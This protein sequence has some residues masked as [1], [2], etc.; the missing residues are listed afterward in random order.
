MKTQV[1]TA[2][3]LFV[4]VCSVAAAQAPGT[5]VLSLEEYEALRKAGQLELPAYV[6]SMAEFR[7]EVQEEAVAVRGSVRAVLFTDQPTVIPLFEKGIT[8]S[9]ASVEGKPAMLSSDQQGRIA[10]A[11]LGRPGQEVTIELEFP[12]PV[13]QKEGFFE[14]SFS[15]PPAGLGK[16]VVDFPYAEVQAHL[17]EEYQETRP[18]PQGRSI[19]EA[20]VLGRDTVTLKWLPLSKE[21]QPV[22]RVR[23]T[24]LVQHH[25]VRSIQYQVAMQ[26][27]VARRPVTE[28]SIPLERGIEVV[29]VGGVKV[30]SHQSKDDRLTI[31][32]REPVIGST[33]LDIDLH[34]WLRVE[35]EE[36]FQV[37][38]IVPEGSS[39]TT[40]FI[41]FAASER[42]KY[43]VTG[44]KNIQPVPVEHIPES[45]LK[46]RA[47]QAFS[48][49]NAEYE[50]TYHVE[51]IEPEFIAALYHGVSFGETTC[52]LSTRCEC[53]VQQGVL[54]AFQFSMPP[55]FQ[56]EAVAGATVRDWIV[57]PEGDRL[58]VV[59][60]SAER[61][62]A[63]FTL[64]YRRN[65]E[66]RELIPI[67]LPEISGPKR[68]RGFVSVTPQTSVRVKV[69]GLEGLEALDPAEVPLAMKTELDLAPLFAYRYLEQPGA[70]HLLVER[71]EKARVETTRIDKMLVALRFSPQG[72]IET[73]LVLE[74]R[75]TDLDMLPVEVFPEA[76]LR[77]SELDGLPR[78]PALGEGANTL[79]YSVPK[80]RTKQ[81]TIHLAYLLP[82][83]P[84]GRGR[85]LELPIPKVALPIDEFG[86]LVSLPE[87]YEAHLA[88]RALLERSPQLPVARLPKSM[89]ELAWVEGPGG[90]PKAAPPP[91][92]VRQIAQA[93]ETYYIDN[94]AYPP[95]LRLLTTPVAHISPGYPF[96][97][98]YKYEV[99]YLESWRLGYEKR[100]VSDEEGKISLGEGAYYT[101]SYLRGDEARLRELLTVRAKIQKRQAGFNY[102]G[103]LIGLV[104]LLVAWGL[105]RR[106]AR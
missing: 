71:F 47:A 25:D 30:A 34:R 9:R 74:L 68:F 45:R 86:L 62:K 60:R 36:S 80:S 61:Q 70:L 41:A 75:N 102:G 51:H 7:A 65:Y 93:L 29:S 13:R 98:K 17:N 50:L 49:W 27:R 19:L 43:S 40:G 12:L 26:L 106:L 52:L 58:E 16:L 4:L 103:V 72:I 73:E 44:Q 48:F 63:I 88:S 8:L 64:N 87:E 94:N 53:T 28:L 95:H 99:N 54:H 77:T 105:W 85:A 46:A 97:E 18:T 42:F 1:L 83:E 91:P 33:D 92:E 89:V 21:V 82:G 11:M 14:T 37:P 79:L 90:S 35:K 20:S 10:W 67:A 3:L 56:L 100:E 38:R 39:E 32:F 81:T 23:E 55:G 84:L 69:E 57:S 96:W 6:L 22:V 5:V 31:Q 15:I 24:L 104:I 59:L 76:S 66:D 78:D 2:A 101:A